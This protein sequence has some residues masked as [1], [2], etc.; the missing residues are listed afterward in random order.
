MNVKPE[1]FQA[2]NE[3]AA[4]HP[5]CLFPL[6]SGTQWFELENGIDKG[7][8]EVCF[9][10]SLPFQSIFLSFIGLII[11]LR[12]RFKESPWR[13]YLH[14]AMSLYSPCASLGSSWDLDILRSSFHP[15][16]LSETLAFG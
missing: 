12:F 15:A 9:M 4:T 6:S 2:I 13:I 8:Q 5:Y 1:V 16:S 11:S 7:L 10:Y 3:Y 14:S